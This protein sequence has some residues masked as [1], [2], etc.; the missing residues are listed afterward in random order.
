MRPLEGIK[1]LDFTRVIAGAAATRMLCD[2]GADV[3]KVEEPSGDRT[4]LWGENRNGLS[5]FFT[6]QNA[7]KRNVCID[8]RADGAREI[9]FELV[10]HADIVCEN[11]R[12]GVMERL[13]LGWDALREHNPRLVMLSISGWGQDGPDAH[14]QAFAPITHAETGWPIRQSVFDDHPPADLMLSVADY[15]AAQQGTIAVLAAL[16]AASA[17]GVGTHIDL[18]MF[19]AMLFCDDYVHHALDGSPIKRLGG[20]YWQVAD[21]GWVMIGGPF[22][23]EWARLSPLAGLIDPAPP[24]S[25]IPTKARL[26]RQAFA[27]WVLQASAD[28]AGF[29]KT[30]D[31]AD[32]AWAWVRTDVEALNSPGAERRRMIV[33]VDD[34]GGGVRR[35]INTPYRYSGY[36]AGLR[37]PAAYRGEHNAEVLADWLG[38][39]G[40]EV[41]A[42]AARGVLLATESGT[43]L[44]GTASDGG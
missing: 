13:G 29:E 31:D 4:H 43:D 27:A 5:G 32:M 42:L 38:Y 23:H 33:E 9:V 25:D 6:Q 28:R 41:D 20:D 2:L 26:R 10:R 12:A 24:G 16:H 40:S 7:G 19:D 21:G 39:N 15:N 8:L 17:T 37:G 44:S 36:E 18:A 3:V 22:P 34:R 11:F 14:R 30:L 35:V 1:V